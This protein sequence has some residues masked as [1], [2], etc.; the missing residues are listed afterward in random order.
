M[1][2]K[3]ISYS[4]SKETLHGF[5]LKRWDKCGVEIEIE[6]ESEV[7]NAFTLAKQL[8][9]EQLSQSAPDEEP[10]QNISDQRPTD[11]IEALKHDIS[12]CKELKVLE[13][14]RLLVTKNPELQDVFNKKIV[15]LQNS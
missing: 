3:T 10:I 6:E 8:V 4:Q 13:S 5:G 2:I 9:N 15:E 7:E 11:T 14:Y 1:I 12:T